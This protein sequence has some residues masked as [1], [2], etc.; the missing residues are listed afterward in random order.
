MSFRFAASPTGFLTVADAR[1]AL[2][3]W[4]AARSQAGAFILRIDDTDGERVAAEFADAIERDLD[5]L[6]LDWDR[7]RHQS[8]RLGEYADAHA[9][10]VESG[11]VYPCYETRQK[12]AAQ[13]DAQRAAGRPP[14]YDR[15]ALL[16]SSA[17]KASFESEGRAPYWRL[18]LSDAAFT[19]DDIVHGP[20]HVEPG[21]M[22]DPVVLRADGRPLA[23]LASVVD[24]IEF[25]VIQVVRGEDYL[26]RTAAEIQ[27]FEAI[28]ARAP[29]YAHH[30]RLALPAGG[31]EGLTLHRLREA[32]VE[33]MALNSYLAK[34]C[35]SD[36][37]QVRRDLKELKRD[38]DLAK[39]GRATAFY[40]AAAITALGRKFVHTMPFAEAAPR[41][42]A[43]GLQD[44]GEAFWHA[45]RGAV[46]SVPEAMDWWRLVGEPIAPLIEEPALTDA[47]ADL[48]PGGVLVTGHLA[49]MDRAGGRSHRPHR[50]RSLPAAAPR[51]DR[52]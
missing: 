18:R 19:W 47:A 23:L 46:G 48:L 35:S 36:A 32:G 27:L 26:S 13:R 49:R 5:W 25:G 51:L 45:V 28:G 3:N 10:L 15:A 52:S 42:Q 31:A 38:F 14:L 24:D 12:L 22:S 1:T 39:L 43:L 29:K 6:G 16:L 40:D 50:T 17:Q 37:V 21:T 44:A 8:A 33:P 9:R 4:L 7:T 34:V 2:L 11:H 20:M 30:S 41:L